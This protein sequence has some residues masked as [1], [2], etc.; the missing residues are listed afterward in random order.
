MIIVNYGD[1]QLQA[2]A[3]F[4]YFNGKYWE[5]EREKDIYA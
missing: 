2:K 1:K 3:V 4:A 5:R